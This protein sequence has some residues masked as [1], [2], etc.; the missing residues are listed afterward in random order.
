MN[1]KA[2]DGRSD[3]W[4]G[5]RPDGRGRTAR[6]FGTFLFGL[7]SLITRMF[8]LIWMTV[9]LGRTEARVLGHSFAAVF[10]SALRAPRRASGPDRHPNH[11]SDHPTCISSSFQR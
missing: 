1:I 8:G 7:I 2:A 11:P 4:S 5:G 9:G 6:R 3:G 10:R